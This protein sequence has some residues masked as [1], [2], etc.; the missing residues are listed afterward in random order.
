MQATKEGTIMAFERCKACGLPKPPLAIEQA[1]DFCSTEC[2][3]R[4]YKKSGNELV[5]GTDA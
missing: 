2:A 5:A 1:D 4:Y 3:R